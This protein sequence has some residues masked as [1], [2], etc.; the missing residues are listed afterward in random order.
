MSRRR[1]RI[2]A[3]D[4]EKE[5]ASLNGITKLRR[6]EKGRRLPRLATP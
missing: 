3:A 2:S 1:R 4:D 6:N 5:E